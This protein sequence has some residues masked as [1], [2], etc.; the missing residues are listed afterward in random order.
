MRHLKNGKGQKLVLATN[1]KTKISGGGI[2]LG[3][4]KK[5]RIFFGRW[6]KKIHLKKIRRGHHRGDMFKMA[7][8]TS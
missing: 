7:S 8:A 5:Q 1:A 6:E 2:A 4:K 3:R